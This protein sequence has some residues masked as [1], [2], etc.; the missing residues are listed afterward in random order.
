MAIWILRVYHTD[1]VKHRHW[2][3]VFRDMIKSLHSNLKN[4]G[5]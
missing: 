5:E 1:H 4:I 2:D 3:F